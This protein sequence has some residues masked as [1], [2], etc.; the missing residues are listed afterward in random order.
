MITTAAENVIPKLVQ[1]L[2]DNVLPYRNIKLF[3][4]L[5]VTLLVAY[6]L[7]YITKSFGNIFER[8]ISEKTSR[9]LQYSMFIKL[10]QLG[11][12]YYE[13]N[14]AGKTLSLLNTEV[15]IVLELYRSHLPSMINHFLFVTISTMYMVSINIYLTMILIPCLLVYYAIGPYLERKTA[16]AFQ[17]V[18]RNRMIFGQRVYESLSGIRDFRAFGAELW[19]KA[20][21]ISAFEQY[22]KSMRSGMIITNMRGSYRRLVSYL[23]A[24]AIFYLGFQF[25]KHDL[26]S[27]G[28]LVAF[29]LLYFTAMLRLTFLVTS[30][31]EQKNIVAQIKTLYEFYHMPV[32]VCE[33]ANPVKLNDVKG[34]LIFK[35]VRFGYAQNETLIKGFN[36]HIKP[37]E[38]V[39]FV[40]TSGNGKSTLF[41]LIG[42][43][44][45]VAE[46]EIVLDG[47][48]I[49]QLSFEQLR[50]TVG[51]VF[52]DAYLFGGSIKDNI[53]F[54]MPHATDE[55]IMASAKAAFA[56]EFIEKLPEQYDTI[57]GERG[58]NLSGGQKQRISIARLFLMQP[59]I[60]LL[61]EATSALDN[62]SEIM[63]KRAL[64]RITIDKTTIVIAHR[65]STVM[66]FD[67]IVV[68][69]DGKAAE[70]GTF[71]QLMKQRGFLYELVEG[72]R[73]D[74]KENL[75]NGVS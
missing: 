32:E 24:A 47:V 50:S 54:G 51:Y 2:I 60:L 14:P 12:S 4:I 21:C 61:D 65:L 64:D 41:K 31:T 56:D 22:S 33:P 10:R 43:F 1:I 13:K 6:I 34:E 73:D 69:H 75:L 71:E 7:V 52:Q 27:T 59:S 48:P 18:S 39:A 55:Q 29:V 26:I 28:G 15:A 74:L 35:N 23:G 17:R 49:N 38:K 30:I 19:D 16:D 42:R 5:M 9:D 66:D 68:I 45:D 62:S 67:K 44:Y 53:R 8:S 36:L 72:Q 40:G 37:G 11:F 70:M 46:G 3:G 25:I 20:K 58:I 63:I 57:V